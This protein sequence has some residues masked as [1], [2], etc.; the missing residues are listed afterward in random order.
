ML[1]E[2]AAEMGGIR[3]SATETNLANGDLQLSRI[4]Q[5]L[6][7]TLQPAMPQVLAESLF[8]VVQQLLY[9]SCRYSLCR[10]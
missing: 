4:G 9:G 10:G 5:C 8:I 1:T 2:R 6:S 3:K 7:G